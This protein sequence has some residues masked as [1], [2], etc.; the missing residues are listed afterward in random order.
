VSAVSLFIG[1]VSYEGTRFPA[2]QGPEGLAALLSAQLTDRGVLHSVVVD[3]TNR[4]DTAADP[5][6][7]EDVQGAL[8]AQVRLEDEWS[9]Y[10]RGHR[11]R[12]VKS[13]VL[14]VLRRGKRWWRRFAP[15]PAVMVERLLN[16]ELAHTALLDAG[17]ASEAPWI[18]ILEDDAFSGD[19]CDLADGLVDV[20]NS[21]SKDMQFVNLSESFDVAELGIARLL[22]P[23]PAAWKGTSA[24]TVLSAS[25][26]V[27][28]TVCAIAYRSDFAQRLLDVYAQM[29]IRPVV[30]I[31]WKLNAALMQLFGS[32]ELGEGS[33]W[34]VVP[35]PID[36][37]S[38]RDDP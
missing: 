33:C 23:A 35:G 21:A 22:V 16:I 8:S 12:S 11:S 1:V 15:P 27:T 26:P 34:W 7:A 36:Q 38:M 24:R 18:V 17:V 31:D 9:R 4:W 5:I 10:L 3:V 29:P 28:N 30:P 37:L 32:G 19:V 20:M 14:S 6:T 13:A 2:A 25:R